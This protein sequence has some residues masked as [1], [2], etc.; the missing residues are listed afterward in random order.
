MKLNKPLNWNKRIDY[1][2]ESIGGW[3][4]EKIGFYNVPT[5]KSTF[6]KIDLT[7]SGSEA[8]DV[9]KNILKQL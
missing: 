3:K 2:V 6:N 9:I 7:A 4:N 8:E 1:I 5:G